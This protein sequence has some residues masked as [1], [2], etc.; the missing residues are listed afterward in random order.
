MSPLIENAHDAEYYKMLHR[1]ESKYPDRKTIDVFKLEEVTKYLN[2]HEAVDS[3]DYEGIVKELN[4]IYNNFYWA[5]L[6]D[7]SMQQGF[8]LELSPYECDPFHKF[9]NVYDID[10]VQNY[11]NHW[12]V[13]EK[14]LV[15]QNIID[16]LNTHFNL[17][18]WE[19]IIINYVRDRYYP[20]FM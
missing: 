10:D 8:P 19:S 2:A 6:L 1:I 14:I 4:N 5:E 20:D 7:E 11:L 15:T 9:V 16:E 3:H 13:D 18:S 17:N 12:C